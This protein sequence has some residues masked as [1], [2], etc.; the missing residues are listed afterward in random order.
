MLTTIENIGIRAENR[1]FTALKT[2]PSPW[3]VFPTVEWRLLRGD[4]EVIGEADVVVFHPHYGL[5]VF[6]IKA[7]AV[8]VREG[9]WFYASGRI[10]K[11]SPFSQ[12]RRNRYA[13]TDKLIQRLGKSA[14]DLLTITHAVWFPDVH[15]SG[16]MPGSEAATRA[17]LFDRDALAKP[18]KY[19]LQLFKAATP[20]PIAWSSVQQKALKEI[21]APDCQLLVPLVVQLDNTLADLQQATEQQIA[22]LRMLR[23]QPRLLVEGCAGSGKTLL[24]ICL[25]R[26][27]AALGKSVLLTCFNRNLADYLSDVLADVPAITVLN[28]HELVRTRV[29]A[30]GLLFQVPEDLQQRIKFFRDDCP[31]LLIEAVESLGEA[32]DTLIVD[33]G[34]D[35]TATWW[36]ALELLG[37]QDFSW[38]C[39]FDRQQTLYQDNKDW[40]PPFN[41]VSFILDT[42]L[43]NTR[44]IGELAAKWG[45]I[46]RPNAFRIEEGLLPEIQYSLNFSLMGGQLKQLLRNLIN[47]EHIAPERIVVLSPYRHTNAK[48]TWSGGLSEVTISTQMHKTITACVRVGTLQGFK[49]LEADVIILVGL[50]DQA[51][52]HPEWLYVGASRA[53]VALYALFLEST[54]GLMTTLV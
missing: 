10:M 16:P 7:G 15:W 4:G 44:P 39:F 11:Q 14:F 47:R 19:L 2:L 32:F 54:I 53:K 52:S 27:H 43:R 46:N 13:L 42:N 25:A 23:T 8:D 35:F 51:T 48:S 31:E 40:V 24:A 22:I 49:G 33:E 34:A 38:Y 45:Q 26:E 37:R 30:A 21:L 1:V 6:E 12:A 50:D 29:L 5:V 17:F 36:V 9:D 41:A 28:F 3:Q 18:E 20:S